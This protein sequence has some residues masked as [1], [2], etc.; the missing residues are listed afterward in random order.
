[1]VDGLTTSKATQS[2]VQA[3]VKYVVSTISNQR[4]LREPGQ[5][6][7]MATEK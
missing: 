3:L 6:A 7:N 2:T 1:M 4:I 5:G